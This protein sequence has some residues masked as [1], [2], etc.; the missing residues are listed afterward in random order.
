VKE[1]EKVLA[2]S[3]EKGKL[4][5]GAS[6][7]TQQLAKNLWLSTDRSLLRKAKELV[8]A[9]RLEGALGKE[10]I[11]ELYVNVVE[12]GDGIYGID[13]AAR[14]YFGVPAR[15]V[16]PAQAAILAGMLPS[17]RRWLP[18]RHP[19]P[20]YKRARI[21]VA[22]LL[23]RGGSRRRRPARRATRSSSGSGPCGRIVRQRPRRLSPRP[24]SRWS[25]TR[26]RRRPRRRPRRRRSPPSPPRRR[27]PL[28]TRRSREPRPRRT[29]T[30]S[31][32]ETQCTQNEGSKRLAASFRGSSAVPL[33][34]CSFG[35]NALHRARAPFQTTL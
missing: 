35:C 9:R 15:S 12:W 31:A 24:P 28:S 10:R 18:A 16:D 32:I 25:P 21:I 6:T 7:I 34:R 20:L 30:R 11:L 17:P 33:P 2:E 29:V 3:W 22:R 13:E 26:T 27:P 14:E 4:I 8:L 5:R 19:A 23:A 1:L